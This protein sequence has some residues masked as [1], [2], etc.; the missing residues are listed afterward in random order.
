M[1]SS[2]THGRTEADKVPGI[3]LGGKV[4]FE[5]GAFTRFDVDTPDVPLTLPAKP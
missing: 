3:L 1:I 2:Y 4:T 5:Y